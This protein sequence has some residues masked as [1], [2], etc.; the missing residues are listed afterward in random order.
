MIKYI[1]LTRFAIITLIITLSCTDTN[2]EERIKKIY[3]NGDTNL[4]K[5]KI[6]RIENGLMHAVL[7]ADQPVKTFSINE[8]MDYYDVPGLSVALIKD[9]QVEW[10][11]SYG[12]KR[13]NSSDSISINTLFQAASL[14]KPVTA[15]VLLKLVE[16]GLIDLDSN[17]NNQLSSWKIPDNKHTVNRKITPKNLILH[18]SGLEV[19][20]YPGYS[21]GQ[22][23]PDIYDILNGNNPS[24]SE[25]A[26]V[27]FEP[28]SRWSYSGAGYEVL[29]LLL[30]EKKGM[31][32]P[33]LMQEE[34]FN[35]LK[36]SNSTFEQENLLKIRNDIAIAHLENGE[37]VENGYNLYP[38]MAA[39]GLW[40]TPIDY[41]KIVCEL[42]KEYQGHSNLILS[43]EMAIN[44]L[45]RHY[46]HM[47][48]GFIMDEE[49]D[50]IALNFSGGN[51]GY[52]CDIYSYLN[53][54]SGAIIMSNS[55]NGGPLIE[56]LFYSISKEYN[57]S[58]WQPDTI[59]PVVL[60]VQVINEFIGEY[61]GLSRDSVE[62]SFVISGNQ[63]SLVFKTADREYP[64]YSVSNTKFVIPAQDWKI[65]TFNS[66][67]RIDSVKFKIDLYG[68]GIAKRRN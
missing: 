25:P 50:R 42:Q 63:D 28:N 47:A 9:N 64:I 60:D 12:V 37:V 30:M 29:Q 32:F 41:A 38:E 49:G 67:N 13:D 21:V 36:I 33:E 66:N 55:N 45:S 26:T 22:Q 43:K 20:H 2:K 39:A 56:S 4:I 68:R 15:L 6:N 34:L 7:L 35:P 59:F 58:N 46:W 11:K 51:H 24:N 19:P 53:A 52:I 27:Q 62:F 17:I 44:A 8:R 18:T 31:S 48:L 23:L 40:T 54:G 16:Q 65:W 5:E 1:K 14:S 10:A 57:W 61:Y 3:I